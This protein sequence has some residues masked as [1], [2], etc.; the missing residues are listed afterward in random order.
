MRRIG[1][2]ALV[3]ILSGACAGPNAGLLMGDLSSTAQVWF[4]EGSTEASSHLLAFDP[5]RHRMDIS[6]SIDTLENAEDLDLVIVTEAGTRYQVLGSF[7]QC[8][9]D[10]ARRQ[11]ERWLPALPA[12]TV[13]GWRVEARRALSDATAAVDV[14]VT[15][16]PTGS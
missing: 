3:G 8:E 7:H 16:I 9:V 10:G 15:W 6:I 4:E 12:E 2:A 1:L 11:C 5:T 14:V 13:G